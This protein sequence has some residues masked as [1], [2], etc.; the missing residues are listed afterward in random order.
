MAPSVPPA[1]VNLRY[2]I[3]ALLVTAAVVGVVLWGTLGQDKPSPGSTGNSCGLECGASVA[4]SAPNPE[5]GPGN[6]SYVMGI[7]PSSGLTWGE[8]RFAIQSATGQNLS[9]TSTWN[10]QIYPASPTANDPI[11]VFGMQTQIWELGS[12]VIATSGQTIH[13][14]LGSTNLRGQGDNIVLFIE[15]SPSFPHGGRVLVGL[16]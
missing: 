16:P 6:Y 1:G 11:A 10:V 3:F 4:L 9:P 13:L 7:T 8:T 5:G 12:S 14:Q 2:G 15:P